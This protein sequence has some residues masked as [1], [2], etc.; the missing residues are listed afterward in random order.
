VTRAGRCATLGC[1]LLAAAAV[2]AAAIHAD[3][4]PIPD[5][6][7]LPWT[8]PQHTSGLEVLL[9]G[10][11]STIAGRAV[12]VRCEGDTDWRVLVARQGGDPAAE[13]GFVGIAYDAQGRLTSLATVAELAGQSV[14]LPLKAFAVAVTKPTK[15]RSASFVAVTEKVP[16]RVL[17]H[18]KLVRRVIARRVVRLG[19]YESPTP[20]YPPDGRV[21][22]VDATFWE[23]YD[24]YATAILTL[25]HES[26]H[27]GGTVG[28]RLANGTVRGDPLA[29][30]KAQCWGM[31]WMPY[32]AE[33]LGDSAADAQA[34][35]TYWWDRD[36]PR[37]E[38]LAGG[39]Y[40]SADCRSGGALDLHL[41]GATAWP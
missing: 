18:G 12:T 6:P 24:A 15:C 41:P 30:A 20:C 11:A 40:W 33:Q 19:P 23:D 1:A 10:I 38:Q 36:Y 31:Q 2:S 16:T 4:A 39:Q 3:T 25:A 28:L 27:L 17:V 21:Q 7:D 8:N 29:E 34:I 14:C 5:S 37:Y 9:S 35:A 22:A 13:L 32:V 26:I